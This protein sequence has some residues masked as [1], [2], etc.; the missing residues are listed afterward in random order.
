MM[1]SQIRQVNRATCHSTAS[2]TYLADIFKLNQITFI[3]M[4]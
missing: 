4:V 2:I 1:K 3:K